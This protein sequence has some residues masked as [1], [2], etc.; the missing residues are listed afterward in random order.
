LTRGAKS[1]KSGTLARVGQ[2]I[3]GIANT[4]QGRGTKCAQTNPSPRGDGAPEIEVTPE[5]VR[6]AKAALAMHCW[7]EGFSTVIGVDEAVEAALHAA[8]AARVLPTP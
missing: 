7:D 3:L 4:S 6:A 5:M 1:C 8:I 2:P